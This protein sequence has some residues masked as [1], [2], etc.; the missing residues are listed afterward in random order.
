MKAALDAAQVGWWLFGGWGLDAQIGR[1]T[2]DHGDVEFWVDRSNA[3][4]VGEAM[5]SIG[6]V[7]VDTQPIEAVD[8]KS[9]Q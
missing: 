4:L 9:R 2:R 6:A 8:S 7:I 1:I 5:L 3:D